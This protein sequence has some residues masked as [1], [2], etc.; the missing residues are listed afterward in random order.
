[1]PVFIG[2]VLDSC[3][4][5]IIDL[6]QNKVK[7]IGFFDNY[8]DRND[9]LGEF[10][11]SGY[12][13]VIDGDL[14]VYSGTDWSAESNWVKVASDFSLYPNIS[15]PD[16][17]TSDADTQGSA[18]ISDTLEDGERYSFGIFDS[19]SNDFKKLSGAALES[20][21]VHV[22]GQQL[23]YTLAD[24]TGNTIDYYTDSAN[25]IVGDV[26]G[27]GLVTSSD[28]LV[29]L[30]GFGGANVEPRDYTIAL[31]EIN[32]PNANPQPLIG[33][34]A[35]VGFFGGYQTTFGVNSF[36][37]NKNVFGE[38][39][40]DDISFTNPSGSSSDPY[41][42]IERI[43]DAGNSENIISWISSGIGTVTAGHSLYVSNTSNDGLVARVHATLTQFSTVQLKLRIFL[44]GQDGSLLLRPTGSNKVDFTVALVSNTGFSGD[45]YVPH[46][47]INTANILQ[48]ISE[49]W[50]LSAVAPDDQP[51]LYNY[52]KK[53][54]IQPLLVVSNVSFASYIDEFEILNLKIKAEGG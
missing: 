31:G 21:I 43:D 25:G 39:A 5:P 10:Q 42:E 14:E 35:Q 1:M 45:I 37:N 30:A 23:A 7:G 8:E 22:V 28:I 16:G 53:I 32:W 49:A 3:G 4:G 20:L 34:A 50:N 36:G 47:A 33:T 29:L 48:T 41:F 18:F 17:V 40:G 11:S 19:Q 24:S 13:S 54:R 26:N 15:V 6:S 2:D 9:L 46:S 38:Q 27:D 12:V 52:V 44:V 51:S